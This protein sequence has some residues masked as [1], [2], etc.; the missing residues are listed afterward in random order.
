M[1]LLII[2]KISLWRQDVLVRKNKI[3]YFKSLK[4]GDKENITYIPPN[5]DSSSNYSWKLNLKV[6]NMLNSK[7]G[8]FSVD[9]FATYNNRQCKRFISKEINF[10]KKRFEVSDLLYCH[11]PFSHIEDVI[12]KVIND[13]LKMLIIMPDI[14][15][16]SW[17]SKIKNITVT[18]ENLGRND[19]FTTGPKFDEPVPDLPFDILAVLLDGNKVD[20]NVIH[21]NVMDTGRLLRA[22]AIIKY[23]K[24]EN[25]GNLLLDTGATSNF[26]SKKYLSEK[27]KVSPN[28]IITGNK[29]LLL[30]QGTKE[31][32]V[33]SEYICLTI[34]WDGFEESVLFYVIDGLN[35]EIILG[36]SWHD[37]NE[38]TI[39]YKDGVVFVG[40]FCILNCNNT[41]N[42]L[43]LNNIEATELGDLL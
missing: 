23:K 27:L 34:K 26:V 14:P 40:K 3:K 25:T 39:G 38:P 10:Y 43:S 8:P 29:S 1:V 6:F 36:K 37:K 22:M 9:C 11:A 19:I 16:R 12:T 17:W 33:P 2:K 42:Q 32:N 21:N 28:A 35:E 4:K 31:D 24:C 13:G 20:V 15:S 41:I 30:K 5:D 18:V 7:F